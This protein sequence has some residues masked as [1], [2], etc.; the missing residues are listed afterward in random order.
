MLGSYHVFVFCWRVSGV[1]LMI[2]FQGKLSPRRRRKRSA[3]ILQRS[4]AR[5]DGFVGTRRFQPAGV[6]PFSHPTGI[7]HSTPLLFSLHVSGWRT[8]TQLFSWFQWEVSG[9]A[10]TMQYPGANCT[11]AWDII[12]LHQT[13][14]CEMTNSVGPSCFGSVKWDGT[15]SDMQACSL[16]RWGCRCV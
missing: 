7:N 11:V 14:R 15:C 6:W 5:D 12:Q 10:N 2:R 3:Q 8:S 13:G 9:R 16:A 4:L 1:P